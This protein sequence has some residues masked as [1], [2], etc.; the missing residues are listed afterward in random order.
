MSWGDEW[1]DTMTLDRAA[2]LIDFDLYNDDDVTQLLVKVQMPTRD[3]PA[4]YSR[5]TL[6]A[7]DAE[8]RFTRLEQGLL[9]DPA[10][11]PPVVLTPDGFRDGHHRLILAHELGLPEVA[12]YRPA[13]PVSFRRSEGT[14]E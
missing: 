8:D 11:V 6:E 1:P 7:N 14:P 3:L 10:A 2:E 13:S 12:V 5:R 9:G 4:P